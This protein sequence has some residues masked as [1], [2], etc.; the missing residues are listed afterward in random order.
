MDQQPKGLAGPHGREVERLR[1]AKAKGLKIASVSSTPV[2]V[3]KALM[4]NLSPDMSSL[5]DLVVSGEK[6]PW[7][8]IN[9]VFPF[10]FSVPFFRFRVR[11]PPLRTRW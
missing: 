7:L 3:L 9:I 11:R 4:E 6:V 8:W 5:F 10:R 1:E 2:E